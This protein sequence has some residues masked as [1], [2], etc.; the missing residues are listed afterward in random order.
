LIGKKQF[1]M[2]AMQRLSFVKTAREM[3]SLQMKKLMPKAHAS[4]ITHYF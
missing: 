2:K 4:R 1:I 3:C